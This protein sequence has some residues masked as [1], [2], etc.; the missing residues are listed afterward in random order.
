MLQWNCGSPARY[1]AAKQRW[2][3]E[4]GA[5]PSKRARGTGSLPG[6]VPAPVDAFGLCCVTHAAEGPK[7]RKVEHAGSERTSDTRETTTAVD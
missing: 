1:R 5:W 3:E 2:H 6:E 7:R 4:A